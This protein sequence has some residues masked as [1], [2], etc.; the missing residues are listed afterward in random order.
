MKPLECYETNLVTFQ[1][2][3]N[4]KEQKMVKTTLKNSNGN[5]NMY[6]SDN[7]EHMIDR[8]SKEFV[9]IIHDYIEPTLRSLFYDY[10][11]SIHERIRKAKNINYAVG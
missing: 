1:G 5:E 6:V 3:G 11:N 8:E 9:H 4:M 2:S 10:V 7:I